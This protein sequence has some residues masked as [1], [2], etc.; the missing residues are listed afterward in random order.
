MRQIVVKFWIILYMRL[1]AA[2]LMDF[3]SLSTMA[4]KRIGIVLPPTPGSWDGKSTAAPIVWK[5]DGKYYMLYQGWSNGSGPRILGLA[6]SED[7]LNWVKYKNNP[8]MF[9]SAGAW[10]QGGFEC[11]SLLKIDGRY[12]LYYTGIGADGKARIGLAT[13]EDLKSWSQHECN[14]IM[15]LGQPGSFDSGGV[16]FP[17][18]LKGKQGYKMVYGGYGIDSM[19]LG[20]ASSSDGINWNRFPHN[21]VF[22]QRGW[23]EDP[24][25]NNWDAGIEVHQVIAMGDNYTM[26]YEGLGNLP[27]RYRLGV[28]FSPDCEVWARSPENPID[29]LTESNVKQDMSTVHPMLLLEDMVLYYVEVVGASMQSQH[30]ICAAQVCPSLVN[31]LAQK[32]LSYPLW[33]ER[34]I[35]PQETI[36]SAINCLGFQKKT[37]LLSS[38]QEG[39]V[40]VEIDP[41]G[42]DQWNTLYEDKVTEGKLWKLSIND[43]FARSRIRF[44]S[45]KAKVSAWIVLERS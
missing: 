27:N 24:C 20:L 7:G 45:S 17:S 38:S 37:F 1:A 13:S 33:I 36:S 43:G 10:D 39:S 23:F 11:G 12:W 2:F 8:V 40:K 4:T 22:R 35:G 9:P 30:R 19:Q 28:A 16:A 6:E 34:N 5:E 25:C 21:P 44:A 31:P 18:V 26:L 15:D 32:A 14:P 29:P 41:A 3:F 42:L